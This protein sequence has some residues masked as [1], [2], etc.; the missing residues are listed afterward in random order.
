MT[1]IQIPG[2]RTYDGVE[3]PDPGVFD[4][5]VAHSVVGFSVRHLMVS[6]TRGR[7]ASFSGSVVVGEDPLAS[8]VE[9]TIDPASIDTG[10]PQRDGHLRSADFFDV[11]QFPE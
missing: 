10:D 6:K 4:L 8:S 5:D 9:V 11:E 3:I 7:F 1:D 2:T